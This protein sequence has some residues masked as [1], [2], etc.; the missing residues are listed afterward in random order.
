V[1]RLHISGG[2]PLVGSAE[3]P[4]DRMVAQRALLLCALSEGECS[5][6]APIHGPDLLAT[7]GALR[8]MG[9]AIEVEADITRIHGVGLRGLTTPP[10]ALDCG[11]SRGTLALLAGVLSG[12]RFGTRL[13]LSGSG[14]GELDHMLGALRARGAH[15]AASGAADHAL[16][17][18]LS[19]APLLPDEAL[20][21]IECELP[22]P[23]PYAKTAILMSGLFAAGAT[24]VAEP[25]LS[26]DHTERMLSAFGVPV[27]RLGSM[28][29]FDP[30]AWTGRLPAM[31][32]LE[33]PG[34]TGA[35][36]WISAA[37]SVLPGSR[38]A[39]RNIGWNPT[40]TGCFDALRL[41]GGNLLA[42]AKGDRAG[43]EPIAELQVRATALRGGAMGGEIAFRCGDSLPA[44]CVLGACAAHGV[45]IV[46]GEAFAPAA[47]PIWG[48]LAAL[49][50]AFGA[51]ASAHEGGLS[52]V[53]AREL[54]GTVVERDQDPRLTW[55]AVLFGLAAQG[56]TVVHEPDD[57]IDD[58]GETLDAL[59][60]LGARIE[61]LS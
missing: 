45:E 25:L 54:R 22:Q 14:Y 32:R 38:V 12:Q 36:A 9:V 61:L 34:D 48:K 17:P 39:L 56:E 31:D 37:A 26:P 11:R 29:G 4:A 16:R 58:W 5:I 41:L 52:V 30:R 35:A 50:R 57:W 19:F 44:L 7:V 49:A 46:D 8:A 42:V 1:P 24:A 55:P 13:L 43:H 10:G 15:V 18:P 2:L 53:R 20:R 3:L 60:Q 33:L 6:A 23:D 21:G 27:R 28:A 51:P 47:D 59:R 40:R